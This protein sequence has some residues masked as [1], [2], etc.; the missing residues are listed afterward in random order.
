[1]KHKEEKVQV[2]VNYNDK[3]WEKYDI[4]FKKIASAAGPRRRGAEV[5]ITR[6]NDI[7]IWTSQQMSC[8]LN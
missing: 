4:D 7:V 5:S 6:T 1:M 8:L 3:R 2:Y